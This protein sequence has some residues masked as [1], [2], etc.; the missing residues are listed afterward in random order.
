MTGKQRNRRKQKMDDLGK[1]KSTNSANAGP[2]FCRHKC[3]G[4]QKFS[5]RG[6]RDHHT[7]YTEHENCSVKCP[8]YKD[9]LALRIKHRCIVV[10]MPRLRTGV[11]VATAVLCSPSTSIS[12]PLKN[13]P[14]SPSPSP[15]AHMSSN[16]HVPLS[17]MRGSVIEKM[18]RNGLP[19]ENNPS[20]EANAVVSSS[21]SANVVSG[22]ARAML[23]IVPRNACEIKSENVQLNS[24]N[25]LP[26]QPSPVVLPNLFDFDLLNDFSQ[27]I[28]MDDSELLQIP[29]LSPSNASQPVIAGVVNPDGN[30]SSSST[31]SNPSFSAEIFGNAIHSKV[32][33][34][35]RIPG[36]LDDDSSTGS[37]TKRRKI[38]HPPE[39]PNNFPDIQP[40]ESVKPSHELRSV[41]TIDPA[42]SL[43]TNSND[44]M[45]S[46]MDTKSPTTKDISLLTE[47]KPY[48]CVY[49]SGAFNGFSPFVNHIALH[50]RAMRSN[51][52]GSVGSQTLREIRF[53][54]MLS[55]VVCQQ[56]CKRNMLEE[57]LITHLN[58][59]N[60]NSLKCSFC[61]T[62]TPNLAAKIVHVRSSHALKDTM[63]C[64]LCG[65]ICKSVE[66][67]RAHLAE[68]LLELEGQVGV[69]RL[70]MGF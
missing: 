31:V 6:K 15:T 21:S 29:A 4:R 45:T 62:V 23:A 10:K 27:S 41:I 30:D 19:G 9:Y 32:R 37:E 1:K 46:S 64:F 14:S 2:V 47:M 26:K 55:C 20:I 18:R 68:H 34:R 11:H 65:K 60:Q 59:Q 44:I 25:S 35:L 12:H 7:K 69:I 53:Q 8:K 51:E 48:R 36:I 24:G 40:P 42:P 49:C 33:K 58:S 13:E 43:P 39:H 63:P 3:C 16:G 5:T 54:D 56:P 38:V 70:A 17:Q 61:Q 50:A 22:L 52:T 67:T 28:G 66:S 57:H